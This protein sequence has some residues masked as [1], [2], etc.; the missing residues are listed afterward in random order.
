[1]RLKH[2]FAINVGNKLNVVE[3]GADPQPAKAQLGFFFA[4]IFFSLQQII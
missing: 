4:A 3:A 1:V 2:Y